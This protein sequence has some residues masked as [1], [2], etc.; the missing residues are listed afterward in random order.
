MAYLI[1]R[2]FVTL[3]G[4]PEKLQSRLWAVRTSVGH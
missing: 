3:A 4:S 1:D 2:R